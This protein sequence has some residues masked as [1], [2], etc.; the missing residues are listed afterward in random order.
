MEQELTE[1]EPVEQKGMTEAELL[2]VCQTELKNGIGGDETETDIAQA[3]DYFFGRLPGVT[4]RVAKDP[5]A[6][7]YVSMDVMDSI[8][9]TVAEVMPT[10]TTDEIA[11]YKPDGEDDEEAARTESSL[12]NHLFLQEYNGDTILETALIDGLL[13]KNCTAKVNWDER[14]SVEY[15]TFDNV[16]SFAMASLLQPTQEGQHVEVVEQYVTDT[17][18]QGVETPAGVMPVE[19]DSYSIKIKRSS[20][21]GRPV[22]AS[23]KPGGLIVGGD[24]DSPDLFNARFVAEEQAIT[25]SSLIEQGFDADIVSKLPEYRKDLDEE[26]RRSHADS[27]E[28][29]S[30]HDSTRLVSVTEIL[31]DIDFDGDGIA[32]RRKIVIGGNNTL[33]S[34]DEW[35]GQPFIGGVAMLV[36]HRYQGISLFERLKSVQ[37]EKSQT[38]RAI[39]DGTKLSSRGR[40]GVLT[41]QANMDDLLT[42][43]TGGVVRMERTD[44]VF[45]LAN[46]EI[47]MS[48]YSLIDFMDNQRKE[49]GGSAV[50]MASQAQ[51]VSGDTAHGIERTMSAMEQ[52]NAMIARRLGQSLIKGIFLELHNVIREHY[53]GE[54]SAMIGGR[55][56]RSVPKQWKKR[57]QV[58]VQIGSS[59]T[60][61]AQ[62]AAVMTDVIV[63]QRELAQT[64]SV[65]YDENKL[66]TAITDKVRLSGIKAPERY[67]VDPTSPEGQQKSQQSQQQAQEKQQQEMQM[68]AAM[69]QAQMKLAQ[70]E[71]MKGLANLQ[72]QQIKLENEGL[73]RQLEESKAL[74]DAMDKADKT[75]F[76]YDKLETDAALKLTEMEIAANADLSQQNEDNYRERI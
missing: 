39:S 40:T 51:H 38:I 32:E 58:S 54:L 7:K 29:S 33:L 48:S 70:A 3:L 53:K 9:A 63:A 71:E 43:R 75:Q 68:Q 65:L 28:F 24:H 50:G 72:A 34:N 41:G 22:I 56:V 49:R 73:K 20:V 66:Y 74:V 16:S 76:D 21:S 1:Q 64:G 23:V 18:V 4:K 11:F 69:T 61:R 59:K 2:N 5:D 42:S 14:I 10:F 12:I 25:V 36:P 55:W 13:H 37:D 17:Q 19:V 26:S 67:F 44:A 60:E 35:K 47:P 8:L 15:E 46:P 57:A 52:E 30:A 45:P 31:M 62:Q 27:S 6:S